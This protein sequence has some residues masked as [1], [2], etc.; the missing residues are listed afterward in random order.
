MSYATEIK[1]KV[2]EEMWNGSRET[3]IAIVEEEPIYFI[4]YYF[5]GYMQLAFAPFHFDMA[6]DL[7]RIFSHQ[8]D[9][10]AWIMH[11]DA[12]KSSIVKSAG[13]TYAICLNKKRY[14]NVD[15]FDKGNAEQ[16]L[17]DVTLALQTNQRIINDFGQLYYKKKHKDA[18]QEAKKKSIGEFITENDVKVEAFSVGTSPRGRVFGAIES[19]RPDWFIV[20]DFENNVTKMSV[21][22]T[23]KVISHLQEIRRSLST[24]GAVTYLGNYITEDGSVDYIM[25]SLEGN[26]RAQLRNVPVMD[27]KTKKIFWDA[28]YVHTI[29]EAVKINKTKTNPLEYVTSIEAKQKSLKENF[30]PEMMNNPASSKDLIFNREQVE[31]DLLKARPPVREVGG[32]KIWYE[33]NPRHR[34]AGGSDVSHG[35]GL[36]HSADG[37]FDFSSTP[38]RWAAAYENNEIQPDDYGYALRDHGAI[39]G[40]CLLIVESN[41]PGG[42]T[43]HVLKGI[44]PDEKLYKKRIT[45]KAGED[46]ETEELGFNTN[47]K[48]KPEAIYA[49]ASAYHDGLIEILDAELLLEMKYFR[50]RNLREMPEEVTSENRKSGMTRHF[51][52]LMGAALAWQGNELARAA[53]KKKIKKVR[54]VS[55]KISEY[56]G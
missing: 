35:K 46:V 3:R 34:Y 16:M 23:D 20:D 50:L 2:M 32:L 29:A 10:V 53:E 45:N 7:K 55:E 43:L 41:G 4:P 1:L 51:D 14:I 9:E 54:E 27:R 44:Y 6:Y 15:S 40:E 21:A 33:Y 31:S 52:K 22:K 37:F 47:K 38:A 36:D 42:I 24:S 28:K 25:K 19:I 18:M 49:F 17:F 39:F 48:T 13:I 56:E 26:E 8:L 12:A 30:E 11:A 5:P